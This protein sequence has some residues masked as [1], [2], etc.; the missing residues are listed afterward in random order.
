MGGSEKNNVSVW[1]AIVALCFRNG[2]EAT[3]SV[4]TSDALWAAAHEPIYALGAGE[5]DTLD[6][7]LL[8]GSATAAAALLSYE[9]A[10]KC[11]GPARAVVERHFDTYFAHISSILSYPYSAAR[12]R[13]LLPWILQGMAH[14]DVVMASGVCYVVA[15]LLGFNKNADA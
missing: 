7:V 12:T 14:D 15:C 4:L 1:L 9:L 2:L 11:A 6:A 5:L 8:M 13:Q 3:E 10:S